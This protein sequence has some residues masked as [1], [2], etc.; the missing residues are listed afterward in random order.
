MAVAVAVGD[1]VAHRAYSAP[2][3]LCYVRHDQHA[4]LTASRRLR[5]CTAESA[6]PSPTATTTYKK[7]AAVSN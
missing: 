3:P 5:N 2:K 7:Q 6:V 4:V 1:G